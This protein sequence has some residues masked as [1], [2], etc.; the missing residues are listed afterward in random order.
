MSSDSI[1]LLWL[2][3]PSGVG[4]S[5]VGWQFFSDLTQS[6]IRVGYLDI[7]QLGMC[8][9]APGSDPDRHLIKARNLG[10]MVAN[11][12]AAGADCVLVSGVVE[13]IHGVRNYVDQ[14]SQTAL[15]LCRLRVDHDVL[16]ERLV[17]RGW[18][19]HQVDA[20][21]SE[22][23]ALDHSDI[24]DVCIDTSG[25]AVSEVIQ[26]LCEKTGNWPALTRP[27]NSLNF[28]RSTVLSP[29]LPNTPGA[30]LW[31][32]GT[33]GVGKS[34]VGWEIFQEVQ[35]AGIRAA[36]VDLEQIGFCRPIPDDDPG[37]HRIKSDNLAGL[38]QTFHSSGARCLIVVGPVN[39]SDAV[40]I[41]RDKLPEATLT[42]CRLHA[43]AEQLGQRI[44]L[45]GQ[46]LGPSIAGDGSKGKAA[47]V[48]QQIS[49]KAVET[50]GVLQ[51]DAIGDLCID[52]DD[53]T[54]ENVARMVLAQ[55]NRWP[56]SV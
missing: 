36:F 39:H 26:Q 1:P 52:T 45:R 47:G 11:F 49:E 4:K 37:N 8:Y 7:D 51:R 24:S 25:L 18:G 5:T 34:T 29:E 55:A 27:T 56:G 10:A 54:I 50:A 12:E 33:T 9:P 53:L 21:L 19:P 35:R 32:C 28:Q 15:T 6:G 46:G 40:Q 2:C 48:L 14:V 23:A 41:Y 38:W 3:G 20:A 30:I 44:K 17:R 31:L 43:G 22:S 16:T 42:L 13:E